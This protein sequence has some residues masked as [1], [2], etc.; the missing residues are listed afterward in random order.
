MV[1]LF[2]Y[3]ILIFTLIDSPREPF[4][5]AFGPFFYL[6]D[7]FIISATFLFIYYVKHFK[8]YFSVT[9]PWLPFVFL[10]I[11]YFFFATLNDFNW[12]INNFV[13]VLKRSYFLIFAILLTFYLKKQPCS[14][15]LILRF[16]INGSIIVGICSIILF[17]GVHYIPFADISTVA[18]GRFITGQ[19][20][21]TSYT[22]IISIVLML[23]YKDLYSL[24]KIF[25][26]LFIILI[27]ISGV[28]IFVI[29]LLFALYFLYY[30]TNKQRRVVFLG[31]IILSPILYYLFTLVSDNEQVKFAVYLFDLK[32]N[33]IL[34][35]SN[36]PSMNLRDYN[37]S[38]ARSGL[39]ENY[40]GHG[41]LV[42]RN[43]I[44]W[45][46]NVYR[47]ILLET[48][49]IGIF[50]YLLALVTSHFLVDFKY[51]KVSF[52]RVA[53]LVTHACFGY[54]LDIFHVFTI[55]VSFG[56]IL[57]LMEVDK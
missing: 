48:G 42:W 57:A 4:N 9:L 37:Y 32:L 25:L 23:H 21:I 28:G 12:D 29:I 36:D 55:L 20:S 13:R 38:V 49:V 41:V 26:N 30:A 24:K 3:I 46:E 54:T 31:M 51:L 44:P 15:I 47:V 18:K 56:M 5:D 53:S 17:F 52:L 50:L 34:G 1:R 40:Y 2:I 27:S 22:S 45:I 10:G 33:H 39:P 6:K 14:K 35:V 8:K 11:I 19:P 16:Y 7:F 43:Y